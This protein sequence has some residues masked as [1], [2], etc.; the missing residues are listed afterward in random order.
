MPHSLLCV[1]RRVSTDLVANRGAPGGPRVSHVSP[2]FPR[3]PRQF[4]VS[5]SCARDFPPHARLTSVLWPCAR[6][7]TYAGGP[8]THKGRWMPWL[9]S[10][11]AHVSDLRRRSITWW[12]CCL[13][14][15]HEAAIARRA[16][17]VLLASTRNDS[18]SR[19]S[20][21]SR[22][23]PVRQAGCPVQQIVG[24]ALLAS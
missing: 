23:S 9:S 22:R 10:R 11:R 19:L 4:R 14:A 1:C 7:T 15:W 21:P 17:D 12:T 3:R 2:D 8:S 20:P 24:L 5:G 18:F 13:Q 16:L 6:S